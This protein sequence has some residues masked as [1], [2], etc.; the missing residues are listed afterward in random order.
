[1]LQDALRCT[2]PLLM[3]TLQWPGIWYKKLTRT[4]A[5][6]PTKDTR[7]CRWRHDAHNVAW[8]TSS[9]TFTRTVTATRCEELWYFQLSDI[10][11]L[12]RAPSADRWPMSLK[13]RYYHDYDNW[14]YHCVITQSRPM[15]LCSKSLVRSTLEAKTLMFQS[16]LFSLPTFAVTS[17]AWPGDHKLS[18]RQGHIVNFQ[19]SRHFSWY[20]E[21]PTFLATRV[22]WFFAFAMLYLGN[23]ARYSLGDN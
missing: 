15:G 1:M 7:R 4:Q 17:R 2:T 3:A 12:K 10:E 6:S 5:S 22:G 18:Y 14:I 8:S 19:T 16:S 11:K 9:V 13:C 20:L 21:L 23:G